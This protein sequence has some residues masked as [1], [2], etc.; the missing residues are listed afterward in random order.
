MQK[1]FRLLKLKKGGIVHTLLSELVNEIA[2]TAAERV[3]H[4]ELKERVLPRKRKGNE[5]V[6]DKK[7]EN[8]ES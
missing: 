3:F 8:G 6:N 1:V 5:D 4:P 7:S 2:H